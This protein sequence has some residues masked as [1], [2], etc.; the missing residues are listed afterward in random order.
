MTTKPANWGGIRSGRFEIH[1]LGR[2]R[3]VEVDLAEPAVR[4][5]LGG[6]TLVPV[7][8]HLLAQT[9]DRV[10]A[11]L[12]PPAEVDDDLVAELRADN[13]ARAA[14]GDYGCV[15]DSDSDPAGV[16]DGYGCGGCACH[17]SAPCRHCMRHLPDEDAEQVGLMLAMTGRWTRG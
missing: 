5:D 14:A 1:A 6:P 17:L 9:L 11:V 13:A 15:F 8:G 10:R 3:M 16:P 7:P 2:G 12:P 4:M